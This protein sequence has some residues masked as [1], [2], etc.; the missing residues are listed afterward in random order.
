MRQTYELGRLHERA[1]LKARAEPDFLRGA[2]VLAGAR[3]GHEKVYGSTEKKHAEWRA[4]C[5]E[6][7]LVLAAGRRVGK[8]MEVTAA[9]FGVSVMSVYRARKA[10]ENGEI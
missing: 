5:R 6:Y 3:E 10:R 8:A 1:V 7:D 2:R 4:M 9:K